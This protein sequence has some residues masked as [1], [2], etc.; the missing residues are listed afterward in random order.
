METSA[1]SDINVSLAFLRIATDVTER[2]NSSG[3]APTGTT[4]HYS[5][6]LP[7]QNTT[8]T[9]KLDT[10]PVKEEKRSWC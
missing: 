4:T 9:L 7:T 10:T 6:A 8:S 2:L 5:K 3:G 1:Y